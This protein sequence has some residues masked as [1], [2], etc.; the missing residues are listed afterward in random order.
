MRVRWRAFALVLGLVLL[1][2]AGVDGHPLA[3][4]LLRLR[5]QAEGPVEVSW[6]TPTVR[7][8]GGELI[9]RLPAHCLAGSEVTSRLSADRAA[10]E[11]RW[12]VDCGERGI[13]GSEVGVDGLSTA[14]TNVVVEVVGADGATARG[15]LHRGEDRFIIPESQGLLA[16]AVDFLQ[17]GVE[18]LLSGPDHIL[19][20]LG[21][22]LLIRGRG[23]LVRAITAFTLGHSLSLALAALGLVRVPS[24][25]VE[26]A[27]AA[28][29]VILALDIV[30]R[31][32]DLP[33]GPMARWPAVVCA[34]FGL[35]HGLGFAGALSLTGLAQSAIPLSLLSFNVGIEVGQLMIVFGALG[36]WA[37]STRLVDRLRRVPATI[38]A[39]VI[40]SLAAF[41][42]LERS[43]GGLG[44]LG[45]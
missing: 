13:R 30:R 18:H 24:A 15:L 8:I 34:A 39:Y 28:S 11:Q 44:V 32:R 31:A 43:L 40:G 36:L 33:D 42:V 10:M 14:S 41:W 27:I 26:V 45:P 23:S 38:P 5:V 12:T 16:A 29:L 9:P 20:V 7:P 22:L 19:F 4:S 21:L 17:L 6:R 37:L 3:P 1:G 35:V 2:A 25:P